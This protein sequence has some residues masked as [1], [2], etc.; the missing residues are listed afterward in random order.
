MTLEFK[1]LE[2]DTD[3]PSQL[4][5]LGERQRSIVLDTPCTSQGGPATKVEGGADARNEDHG[6]IGPQHR[7]GGGY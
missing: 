5:Q 2:L 6:I 7:R 4:T 3:L 1:A